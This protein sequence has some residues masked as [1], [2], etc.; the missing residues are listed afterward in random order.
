VKLSAL[1]PEVIR[2]RLKQDGIR[3]RVGPFAVTVRADDAAFASTL[4][5]LY[6]DF[7]LLEANE[8][9]EFLIRVRYPRGLRRWWRRQVRFFLDDTQP[10]EPFPSNL[11]M[12]FFEWGLNWCIYEHAHEFLIVH[13]AVVE[14]KGMA[15]MLPA[16]PGSGKSTLCAALVLAGWR[17]LS[18][19][20][21]LIAAPDG[22]SL[23]IPRPIG[24]KEHSIGIIR[25]LREKVELGPVFADTRKGD[26]AHLRPPAES[27]ARADEAAAI[28]WVVFPKYGA[29]AENRLDPLSKAAGFAKASDG[30]FNYEMLRAAGF[31]FL[32]AVVDNCDCFDLTFSDLRAAVDLI[33][34]LAE[35]G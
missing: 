15:V 22:R 32:A 7:P 11:A 17:L 5:F 4:H 29:G 33:E 24:L 8:P 10:F 31:E 14:R 28:R 18:D 3:M 19:E 34:S 20:F 16:A 26:V 21:A 9:S 6:Q 30:C 12:P 23:P 2:S 27:V 13:A 25:G 35:T 1:S